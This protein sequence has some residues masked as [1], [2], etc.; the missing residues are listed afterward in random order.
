MKNALFALILV[1]ACT[2]PSWAQNAAEK[3]LI[4]LENDWLTAYTK[5]DTK[6]LEPI[7]ATDYTSTG[8]KG[9]VHTRADELK[10]VVNPDYAKMTAVLSD[11]KVR[12][13]GDVGIVFGVNTVTMPD[14]AKG[15]TT[16]E[17]YRFTDIFAKHNGRWQCVASHASIIEK[18]K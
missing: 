7:L 10:D 16:T 8:S 12:L 18:K 14:K 15:K 9:Q 2:V 11:M 4:K 1:I 17:A 3:E 6:L 13:Y 5:H